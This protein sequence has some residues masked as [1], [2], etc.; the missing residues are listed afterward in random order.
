[1]Y[2]PLGYVNSIKQQTCQFEKK[3]L[4][5]YEIITECI[6]CT[7]DDLLKTDKKPSM[8]L[9]FAYGLK[10]EGARFNW[11]DLTIEDCQPKVLYTEMPIII[12]RSYNV[13]KPPNMSKM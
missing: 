7:A 10:I 2:N 3:P 12:I 6:N 11:D 4:D 8:I 5:E 1:M 9:S 13:N